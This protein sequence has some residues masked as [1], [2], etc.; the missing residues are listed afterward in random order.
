MFP[1]HK[2]TFKT[3]RYTCRRRTLSM[4]YCCLHFQSFQTYL[5]LALE[6]NLRL[7]RT[8]WTWEFSPNS[9][10]RQIAIFMYISLLTQEWHGNPTWKQRQMLRCKRN[11]TPTSTT[12]KLRH[13]CLKTSN[14]YTWRTK[15]F[16]SLVPEISSMSVITSKLGNKNGL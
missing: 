13:K 7:Q 3:I 14:W 1:N 8:K 15:R 12:T 4:N 11:S 2:N 10:Q 6:S 16:F 5:S 9:I